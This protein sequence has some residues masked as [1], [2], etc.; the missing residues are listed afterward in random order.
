[1]YQESALVKDL[2]VKRMGSDESINYTQSSVKMY[3]ASR[4]KKY[5]EDF[6]IVT[7]LTFPSLSGF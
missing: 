2:S 3:A 5:K 1:M 4:E 7:I 6:H